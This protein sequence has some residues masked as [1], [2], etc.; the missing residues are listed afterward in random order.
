MGKI[1]DVVITGAMVVVG[2]VGLRKLFRELS[3]T[4]AAV[5]RPRDQDGYPIHERSTD[6]DT[7]RQQ[8]NGPGTPR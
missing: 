5:V 3:L 4:G 8:Q 7:P 2:T 6:D 1:S